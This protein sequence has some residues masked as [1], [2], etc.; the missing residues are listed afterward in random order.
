MDFIN[1]LKILKLSMK[2]K[3]PKRGLFCAF[4]EKQF[5]DFTK[6]DCSNE[7]SGLEVG[8]L[9]HLAIIQIPKKLIH[10][11]IG[12]VVTDGSPPLTEP[13]DSNTWSALNCCHAIRKV[14]VALREFYASAMML[15]WRVLWLLFGRSD[16]KL[17]KIPS[18]LRRKLLATWGQI[19]C[20]YSFEAHDRGVPLSHHF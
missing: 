17:C 18:S 16:E 6:N 20:S 13:H 10:T 12:Q 1:F 2:I 5:L 15:W 7:L 3:A 9:V 14:A 4:Y 8:I 19:L 11:W